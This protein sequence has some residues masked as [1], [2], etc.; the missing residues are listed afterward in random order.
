MWV[1]DTRLV[2]K[3]ETVFAGI[4]GSAASSG[5]ADAVR[6]ERF[7]AGRVEDVARFD[8]AITA[9]S[10]EVPSDVVL[11]NKNKKVKN[12]HTSELCNSLVMWAWSRGV[13][14]V[15]F[16]AKAEAR[17][18]KAVDELDRTLDRFA[19]LLFEHAGATETETAILSND[20]R[21][22]T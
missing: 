15:K 3:A 6:S 8:L 17:I 22:S 14:H 4:L 21:T 5:E 19:S 7:D 18:F 13:E 12:Q 2:G 9:A 11:K 1:V 16:T 10:G 20:T